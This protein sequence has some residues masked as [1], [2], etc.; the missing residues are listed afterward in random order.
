M[1]IE[2]SLKS[3]ITVYQFRGMH[4]VTSGLENIA[5]FLKYQKY[6]K[7]RKNQIFFLDI[8]DIYRAF[9]H[10]LLKYNIY[11]QTVVC[12]CSLHIR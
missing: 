8:F 6:I 10:T 2:Y 11:Y 12:V 4:D 1:S 7:Y 5:I 9:A 3:Q